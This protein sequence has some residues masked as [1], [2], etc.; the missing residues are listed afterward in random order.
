MIHPTAAN[1]K[2]G[3]TGSRARKSGVETMAGTAEYGLG[4]FTFPRGW[5]MIARSADLGDVPMA[6]RMF[7]RDLALYRGESGA[8]HQL[9]AY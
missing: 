1:K 7:G 8:P 6:L 9:D 5:F 4:E 3:Q 2:A